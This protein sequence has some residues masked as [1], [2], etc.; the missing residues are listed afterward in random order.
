[1]MDNSF[2]DQYIIIE[3]V[4]QAKELDKVLGLD[5][6]QHRKMA[7]DADHPHADSNRIEG[8]EFVHNISV[9]QASVPKFS[10]ISTFSVALPPNP[11]V[12]IDELSQTSEA[13]SGCNLIH[14]P[15]SPCLAQGSPIRWLR[16]SVAR[17]NFY[18]TPVSCIASAPSAVQVSSSF[19]V[20]GK[21]YPDSGFTD[22]TFTSTSTSA[23]MAKPML[24]NNETVSSLHQ[25]LGLNDIVH[26]I[27]QLTSLVKTSMKRK[28]SEKNFQK[29]V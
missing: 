19:P 29:S 10:G 24:I 11:T 18:A 17:S 6:I 14:P 3:E 7:N 20:R 5:A 25:E 4:K 23:S 13:G 12:A 16:H 28:F 2:K 27:G 21:A 15:L 9:H 1:M 8:N 22:S 26:S